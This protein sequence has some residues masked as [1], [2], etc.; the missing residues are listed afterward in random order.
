MVAFRSDGALVGGDTNGYQDVYV[1]D[2]KTGKT[3]RVSV[4]SDGTQVFADS[5]DPRISGNG[6]YVAWDTDGAFSGA[7]VNGYL[8]V[9]RHDLSTGTTQQVSRRNNGSQPVDGDSSEPSLSASG[10]KIAFQSNDGQMTADHAPT[11]RT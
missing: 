3:S 7:D 5:Q 4:K 11:I 1:H 10:Q 2:T 9:Y 6:R 8:D